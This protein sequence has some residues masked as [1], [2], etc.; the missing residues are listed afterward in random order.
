MAQ[1]YTIAGIRTANRIFRTAAH[2]GEKAR[3]SKR[4]P[5]HPTHQRPKIMRPPIMTAIVGDPGIPRVIMGSVAEVPAAWAA[6][7][8]AMMPAEAPFPNSS[9]FLAACLAKPYAMKE[10]GVAPPGLRPIQHPI[11]APIRSDFQ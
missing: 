1:T 5:T 11:S 2:R 9:L 4:P 3:P 6:A 8:G 10:A 7:S